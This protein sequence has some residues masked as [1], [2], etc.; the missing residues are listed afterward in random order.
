MV[1][2]NA[3]GA[4]TSAVVTV[5]VVAQSGASG[6]VR[7][8]YRLGD[9]SPVRFRAVL[10]GQLPLTRWG[11]TTSVGRGR[12]PTARMFGRTAAPSR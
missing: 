7:V 11:V 6:G 5:T 4:V 8:W 9:A 1:I 2:T 3:Q 10:P 12:Q